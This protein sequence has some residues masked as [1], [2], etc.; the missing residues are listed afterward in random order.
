MKA[1][2]QQLI[3]LQNLDTSIRRL[4]A[5]IEAIPR[6]RAEIENEFD[7]RASEIRAL[8]TRRDDARHERVRLEKEVSEQRTRADG[9]VVSDT[10]PF[11]RIVRQRSRHRDRRVARGR[12][13][14][15]QISK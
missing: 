2:L 3:A 11:P 14:A 10:S 8:E 12:P 5:E 1:E 13:V 9:D 7:Q 15:R 4:Q 6:R